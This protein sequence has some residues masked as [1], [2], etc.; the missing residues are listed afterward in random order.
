MVQKTLQE[1]AKPGAISGELYQLALDRADQLGQGEFFMG[2]E[3]RRIRL[4]GH[5]VGS[6][7]DEYPFI[8]A[9]QSLPM[10]E[11][12]VIALEP[13]VIIPEK[14]VVGIEN[15]HLLTKEGLSPLTHYKEE[16]TFV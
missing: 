1:A 11:N 16:I 3:S 9:N 5:G 4:V 8:A 13:K 7:L 6:E 14:G 15:T 2:A 10:K 12:M